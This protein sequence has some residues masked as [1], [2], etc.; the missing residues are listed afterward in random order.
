MEIRGERKQ[1]VFRVA[2]RLVL[3]S[4]LTAGVGRGAED[5]RSSAPCPAWCRLSPLVAPSKEAR[6]SPRGEES[7]PTK[8]GSFSKRGPGRR[9]ARRL[10]P[11]AALA[12]AGA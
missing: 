12:A 1:R 8:V 11:A 3:S 5:S 9:R 10:L 2:P 4:R 7:N 6:P